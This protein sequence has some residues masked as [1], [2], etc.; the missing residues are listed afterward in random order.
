MVVFRK[1]LDNLNLDGNSRVVEQVNNVPASVT[2]RLVIKDRVEARIPPKE[3]FV[4]ALV[5]G[6]GALPNLQGRQ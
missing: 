6:Q 3:K 2:S 4:V 5:T 1:K